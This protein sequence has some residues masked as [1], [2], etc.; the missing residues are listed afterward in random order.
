M[1]AIHS[2]NSVWNHLYAFLWMSPMFQNVPREVLYCAA[3]V[4]LLFVAPIAN[5]RLFFRLAWIWNIYH[6]YPQTGVGHSPRTFS[7]AFLHTRTFPQ[8]CCCYHDHGSAQAWTPLH[9]FS[10]TV[11]HNNWMWAF[12]LHTNKIYCSPVSWPFSAAPSFRF[13]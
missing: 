5:C 12:G 10:Y 8:I 1:N 3:Y 9:L 11:T 2:V 4:I 6:P 13:L 7:A